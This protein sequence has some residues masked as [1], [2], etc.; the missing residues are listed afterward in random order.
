MQC[1]AVS[2]SWG[3]SV[4]TICRARPDIGAPWRVFWKPTK[5]QQTTKGRMHTLLAQAPGESAQASSWLGWGLERDPLCSQRSQGSGRGPCCS[6]GSHRGPCCSQS[7]RL[8]DSHRAN[9]WMAWPAPESTHTLIE[10]K[11][12]AAKERKDGLNEPLMCILG[13][14]GRWPLGIEIRW[15]PQHLQRWFLPPHM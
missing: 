5:L 7:S 2:S 3:P 1:T 6:Q 4:D 9:P 13:V 8:A 14:V 12:C 10:P 11:L 15:P